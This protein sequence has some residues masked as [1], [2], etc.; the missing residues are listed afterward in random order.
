MANE[1]P[2]NTAVLD[3]ATVVAEPSRSG[4]SASR[5]PFVSVSTAA[6]RLRVVAEPPTGVI[7]V[8]PPATYA[9]VPEIASEETAALALGAQAPS[10]PVNSVLNA[11]RREREVDEPPT[12]VTVVN[13]PPANTV[14]PD[15]ASADTVLSAAGAQA[16]SAPVDSVLNAARR[17][18]EVDEPPTGVT[19]VNEP[20]A[21]TVEPDT[22]SA[23]TAPPAAGA[24]LVSDPVPVVDSA[25]R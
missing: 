23:D 16:P 8:K 4:F 11:A 19:V 2:T 22:A 13:E 5:E 6:N 18:R 12:G 3:T 21:Y 17:E 9:V 14:E 24:Q 15:T 20:P 10:A 1:P 25:A 7:D